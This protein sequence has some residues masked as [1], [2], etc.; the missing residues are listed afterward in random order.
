[1]PMIR[2]QLPFHSF[3]APMDWAY[4]SIFLSAEKSWAI[5]PMYI[6]FLYWLGPSLN[7]ASLLTRCHDIRFITCRE[8]AYAYIADFSRTRLM[9][10]CQDFSRR[11]MFLLTKMENPSRPGA[12]CSSVVIDG[13][14]GR[15]RHS[16]GINIHLEN[17]NGLDRASGNR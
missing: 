10:M 6:P 9:R 2:S 8:H 17:E 14:R 11:V 12:K 16:A 1:M 4:S 3:G 7:T 13:P 15:D 5:E